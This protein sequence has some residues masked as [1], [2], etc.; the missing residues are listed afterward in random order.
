MA[1]MR[2]P[3]IIQPL[4]K[5]YQHPETSRKRKSESLVYPLWF[6]RKTRITELHCYHFIV[7]V[8]SLWRSF[9]ALKC[10][11]LINSTNFKRI[12]FEIFRVLEELLGNERNLTLSKFIFLIIIFFPL[13]PSF[14]IFTHF[15]F[16]SSEILIAIC[17]TID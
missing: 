16:F 15:Y 13:W 10:R 17:L 1:A 2:A 4:Q 11:R 6:R 14:I 3:L 12:Q 9:V 8:N 7:F 5:Q